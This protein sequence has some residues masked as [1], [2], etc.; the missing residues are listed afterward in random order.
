MGYKSDRAYTDYNHTLA[1]QQIYAQYGISIQKP[2]TE[3]EKQQAINDDIYKAIDYI[4]YI[5]KSEKPFAIQ[6]RTRSNKYMKYNDITIRFERPEN[7]HEDRKES[8]LYKLSNYFEENPDVPFLMMY[9]VRG[10]EKDISSDQETFAKYTFVDLR[11][12]NDLIKQEK[13]VI[14]DWV[15]TNTSY[16][17]NGVMYVPIKENTDKSSVFATLDITQLIDNFPGVV[18]EQ[19]G[20]DAPEIYIYKGTEPHHLYAQ[21][22]GSISVEQKCYLQD[23]MTRKGYQWDEM[24]LEN[25]T[26]LDACD[27]IGYIKWTDLSKFEELYPKLAIK[28]GKPIQKGIDR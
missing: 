21:M 28:P 10:E 14:E 11:K 3:A 7:T 26:M 9:A 23:L 27:A 2:Q 6:E 4:G 1:E 20:F 5:E 13:I 8:E 22:Q 19:H 24:Y 17:H 16:V 12:I 15:Y 25:L 18:L